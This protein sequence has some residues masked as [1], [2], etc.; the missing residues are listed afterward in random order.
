M[1][2][3]PPREGWQ[4]GLAARL[5]DS[6]SH[7][8]LFHVMRNQPVSE[9][10]LG[11]EFLKVLQG[12][13]PASWAATAL[14]TS[15]DTPPA[16]RADALIEVRAPNGASQLI[17]VEAKS[18]LTPGRTSDLVAQLREYVS[19]LPADSRP[20]CVVAAPYLSP[21]TRELLLNRGCSYFDMTGNLRL[22]LDDPAMLVEKQGAQSNPWTQDRPL[23]SLKGPTA[24]RI[25]R[26]LIDFP[27]PYTLSELAELAKADVASV[28][29]VVS[30]LEP[31]GLVRREPRGPLEE[32]DWPGL[33]RRWARDYSL[34]G[35]NRTTTFLEPRGALAVLEKLRAAEFRYAITGTLATATV[36]PSVPARLAI[37]YVDSAEATA[38]RLELRPIDTGANVI[39]AEPYDDVVYER[40]WSIE[41]GGAEYA[42]LSQVAAD[43]LTSPGR[44]PVGGDELITWMERNERMWRAS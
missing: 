16:G 7:R 25:V 28:Y 35:S 3:A 44:G 42:A 12:M 13:L 32:V 8:T 11:G 36:A 23:R 40:T 43:L 15:M 30:F 9:N 17:L 29:R 18:Q 39:L 24:G 33:I 6:F 41:E 22:A 1:E 34:T 38:D 26:A 37:V 31:E 2:P 5:T 19:W 4:L 27:P 10:Q 21:S 20:A 14:E